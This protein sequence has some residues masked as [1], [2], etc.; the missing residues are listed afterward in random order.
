MT[1]L[2]KMTAAERMTVFAALL[3][4]V[5]SYKLPMVVRLTEAFLDHEARIDEAA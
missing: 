2:V 4:L 3:A 1:L 5:P